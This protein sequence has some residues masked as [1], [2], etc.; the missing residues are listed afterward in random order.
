MTSAHAE[1]TVACRLCGEALHGADLYLGEVPVCNR[2]THD[3]SCRRHPLSMTACC[4]CG[5]IQL[6]RF[7]P[8][9]AVTPL[10]PWI[11]YN[12]PDQ[13]LA[14]AVERLLGLLGRPPRR[15]L[16]TGPF[17]Q[18]LLDGLTRDG[19]IAHAIDLRQEHGNGTG[20]S[21]PYLEA[22]QARLSDGGLAARA[23]GQADIV[24]C[25]YMLEHCHA[26]LDALAALGDAATPD[27]VVL[28]EVP[29]C[30][31]FLRRCDYSFPWEEHVCYFTETSLAAMASSAGFE[32]Q[33][34]IRSPG[35]LEDS[36]MA[37]LRRIG[38]RPPQPLVSDR[39]GLALFETY[40][41]RFA[42]TG[43]AWA[44]L[45]RTT[46]QNG[47]KVA[48]FGAGHQAIMFVNALRLNQSVAAMVDDNPIKCG[49]V[50]PGMTSPVISSAQML[51]DPSFTTCLLAV[52]PRTEAAIMA[53]CAPLRDRGG[54]F[55]SVF[56]SPDALSLE[57]APT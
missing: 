39:E 24:V 46:R 43:E 4:S 29:D 48:V 56:M 44:R 12:E 57:S 31:S 5:L 40:R 8:P 23:G 33:E 7:P 13:H 10:L 41:D 42:P 27:G 45:L 19:A 16:G 18:P 47:G 28:V 20:A 11:S 30:S 22:I 54:R 21:Y 14:A 2:F 55:Y 38:P 37:V 15:V 9:E 35:A 49:M 25:R 26:P 32:V 1:R 17:D 53:K 52:S 34:I 6:W 51:A 50:A 3:G 36:L